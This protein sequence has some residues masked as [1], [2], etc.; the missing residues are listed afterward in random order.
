[1]IAFFEVKKGDQYFLFLRSEKGLS[2][3]SKIP[4]ILLGSQIYLGTFYS[5]RNRREYLATKTTCLTLYTKQRIVNLS[6]KEIRV[7]DRVIIL[8]EEDDCKTTHQKISRII[9]KYNQCK[10]AQG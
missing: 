10:F 7:V 1:M 2:P 3:Q 8:K 4:Q 9:R 6:L 5:G